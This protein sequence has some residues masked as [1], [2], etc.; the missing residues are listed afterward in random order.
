MASK[1]YAVTDDSLNNEDIIGYNRFTPSKA[2]IDSAESYLH[3]G[4]KRL[5]R[6]LP[7]V[8]FIKGPNIYRNLKNYARQYFG[9]VIKNHEKIILVNSFWD[10]YEINDPDWLQNYYHVYDGGNYY[11]NIKINLTT[12]KLFDFG[13]NGAI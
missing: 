11:W 7:S 1:I 4:L 13:V 9:Y 5:Y 3:L 12:H 10:K 2:D 6:R 8:S